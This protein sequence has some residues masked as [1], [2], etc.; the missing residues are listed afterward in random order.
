MATTFTYTPLVG[1]NQVVT[2]STT[3]VNG[4]STVI[5]KTSGQ[6]D[7]RTGKMRIAFILDNADGSTTGDGVVTFSVNCP[8]PF[9]RDEDGAVVLPATDHAA[10]YPVCSISPRV[11]P[12]NVF[13]AAAINYQ[14]T[15]GQATVD[16]QIPI[17]L[18]FTQPGAGLGVAYNV[19]IDFSASAAS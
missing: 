8:L 18:N 7:G 12:D 15:A 17:T 16:G 3:F 10:Y 6:G 14:I 9:P 11:H 19:D 13:P 2:P 1:F 5:P 4:A